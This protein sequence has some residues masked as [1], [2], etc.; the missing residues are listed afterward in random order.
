MKRWSI[1][2]F[3]VFSYSVFFAT[4]LYACGFVGNVMVPKSIDSAPGTPFAQ[5][6]LVDI[7]LLGVFALQHSVMARPAFKR[8]LTA[9]IPASIERST[10]TLASSLALIALFAFWQ[11]P[12]GVIWS[13]EQPLAR[14]VLHGLFAGGWL[15]VLYTTFLINHFDLF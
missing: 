1:L 6:L 8:W 11:P 13:I 3:G 12:G 15:L 4:F 10:Y 2:L 14:G 5:A 7:L 9:R